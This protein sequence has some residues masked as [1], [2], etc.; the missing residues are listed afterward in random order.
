MKRFIV[1]ALVAGFLAFGAG[2]ARAGSDASTDYEDA[3]THPLRLAGYLAHPIGF[4]AEWLVG[5]PLHYLIS[6][7]YL[8]KFFGYRALEEEG[9]YRKYGERL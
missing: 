8:D 1:A 6:R 9:M 4:A 7:P 2:Q 3:I 5:R